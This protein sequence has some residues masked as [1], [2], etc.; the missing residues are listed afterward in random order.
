ME[1][2]RVHRWTFH[3]STYYTASRKVWIIIRQNKTKQNKIKWEKYYNP[4]DKKVILDWVV[5]VVGWGGV[6]RTEGEF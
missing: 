4:K 5:C 6:G 1:K 2:M 3:S